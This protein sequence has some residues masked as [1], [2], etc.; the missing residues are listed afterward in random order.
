MRR[1]LFTR[2][3]IP[4]LA[5]AGIAYAVVF[6]AM[7]ARPE[8]KPPNQLALPAESR[9]ASTVS[10][11][12]L[13]EANTRNIAVASFESVV[14][15]EVAVTEGQRVEAGALLFA[16]DRRAAEASVAVATTIT[17]K[18][19]PA[20]RRSVGSRASGGARA[21][22]VAAGRCGS[23]GATAGTARCSGRVARAKP[24]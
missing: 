5:V 8:P 23:R 12:G 1:G 20:V 4:A 16:L 10:G 24:A 9:F 7:T 22:R 11:S 14:V 19:R 17:A 21:G 13:I 2:V 3:V 6:S 18:S 15:A